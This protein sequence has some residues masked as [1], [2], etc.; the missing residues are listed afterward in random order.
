METNDLCKFIDGVIEGAYQKGLFPK[1][2]VQQVLNIAELI[3]QKLQ[4]GDKLA[5]ENTDLK[6]SYE[7]LA[8]QHESLQQRFNSL[9]IDLEEIQNPANALEL[10]MAT[11]SVEEISNHTP[12]LVKEKK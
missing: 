12:K 5:T 11:N 6:T 1:E 8:N 3:K 2:G 9:G 7:A 10:E 4:E